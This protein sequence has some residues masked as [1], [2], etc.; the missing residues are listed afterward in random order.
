MASMFDQYNQTLKRESISAG[1]SNYGLPRSGYI[2]IMAKEEAPIFSKKKMSLTVLH[3]ITHLLVANGRIVV[4]F[5]NK[6]LLRL[7]L[8][9]GNERDGLYFNPYDFF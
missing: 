6:F 1:V 2:S 3:N 9:K 4:F 7:T 8:P 5:A